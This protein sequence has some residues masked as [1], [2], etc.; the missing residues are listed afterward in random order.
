MTTESSI[1]ASDS[2]DL[3]DL[4]L[5]HFEPLVVFLMS[6]TDVGRHGAEDLAQEVMLRAWRSLPTLVG[7]VRDL[8]PWLRTVARRLAID[9]SRA[10]QARPE[11]VPYDL[12][13]N[14]TERASVEELDRYVLNR[15]TARSVVSLL[16]PRQRQV[17]ELYYLCDL[18]IRTISRKLSVP[19]GTVKSR[20]HHALRSMRG[21]HR[22]VCE[23][24][25]C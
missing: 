4:F 10:R 8:G 13:S 9:S 7:D 16:S 1:F 17:V 5:T 3:S 6:R 24:I 23:D 19:E 20:L 18:D 25:A 11:E 14:L 21:E 2:P 12:T 22:Q 15:L